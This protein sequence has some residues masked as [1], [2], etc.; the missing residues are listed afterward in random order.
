MKRVTFSFN[1][2]KKGSMPIRRH[3]KGFLA[4]KMGLKPELSRIHNV[5]R[6]QGPFDRAHY[7]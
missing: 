7:L 5:V 2:G 1:I 6:V 4:R 3:G